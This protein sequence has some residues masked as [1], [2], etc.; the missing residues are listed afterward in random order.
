LIATVGKNE[1]PVLITL[2]HLY[3]ALTQPSQLG[4]SWNKIWADR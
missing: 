3:E 4:R 2:Q 1:L